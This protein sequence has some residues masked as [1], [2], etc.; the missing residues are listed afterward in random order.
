MSIRVV[1][2]GPGGAA[3]RTPAAVEAIRESDVVVGY[4]TY[5]A[6]VEDLLGGKEVVSAKMRQEVYRARVAVEMARE[7]KRVA[8]ISDG[9][10]EIFG[11]APLVLEMLSRYGWRPSGLEVVPGVTAALAA[12]ARLGA[13]LGSDVAFINLSPLLTP[14]EVI[15]RRV[16]AAA[17]ADYV[18]AF[19]NPIDRGLLREALAAVARWRGGQ[20]P[21]GV[22]KDAYRRGERVYVT[23]LDSVDVDAVDMRTTVIV[24][25]SESYIW[26]GYI[27]TPRGYHRKYAYP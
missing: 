4:E 8:V 2:F 14:R 18:I 1:G 11:M 6:M 9:D 16:E 15:L 3:L 24:G 10:P 23:T 19:Y 17:A 26:E 13:P 21:V 7:G 12:G 27:I 25:N 22:V 20:T 5:V